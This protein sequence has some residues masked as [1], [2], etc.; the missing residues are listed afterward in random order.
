M[1]I[2]KEIVLVTTE[3]EKTGVLDNN[4]V[5]SYWG[6]EFQADHALNFP[7]LKTPAITMDLGT[8]GIN[9]LLTNGGSGYFPRRIVTPLLS[10]GRVWIVE[11]APMFH[12]P[13]Y[14]IYPQTMDA[15]LIDIILRGLNVSLSPISIKK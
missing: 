6:P 9:Y 1:L 13:A 4:Y 8:M 11:S 15:E 5:M 10:L 12:Y 2:D 3:P 7:N 14:M